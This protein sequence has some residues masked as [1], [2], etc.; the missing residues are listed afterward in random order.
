MRMNSKQTEQ[1]DDVDE[2]TLK[3]RAHQTTHELK[4]NQINQLQNS[5]SD[6]S[7]IHDIKT[8]QCATI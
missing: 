3:M 1:C 7:I 2:K 6:F 5:E 8:Q 4:S